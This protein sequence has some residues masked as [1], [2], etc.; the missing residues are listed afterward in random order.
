M[1]LDF[2]F[3]TIQNPVSSCGLGNITIYRNLFDQI[4]TRRFAFRKTVIITF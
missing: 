1:L 2:W 4:G 3:N